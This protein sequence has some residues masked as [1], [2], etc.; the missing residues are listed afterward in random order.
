[1]HI[2]LENDGKKGAFFIEANGERLAAMAFT[3]AGE[4]R[5]IID[6]TEVDERLRGKGAGRQMLNRL[7]E[8]VREHQIRVIPLCPFA[9]SVFE[10]DASIRDVLN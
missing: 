7:V 1:M 3:M 2:Q 10:K 4:H 6:H 8:Y 5:M 9:K